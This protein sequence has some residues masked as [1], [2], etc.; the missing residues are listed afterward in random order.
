[1]Q[2]RRLRCHGVGPDPAAL[3]RPA[4]RYRRALHSQDLH[5]Q[6]WA[7]VAHVASLAGA[8][9]FWAWLDRGLW[10]FG[11]EWDFLL[12]RGLAYAPANPDSIWFPHNEHWSTLPVLLWRGLF[13]VFHLSS[14]WP[15]LVPVL[16]AQVVVMHLSWRLCRRAGADPWVAGAA[17][18]MLGLLGAGA[19]DLGWAFQIGFDG[20]VMFGLLALDLLDRPTLDAPAAALRRNVAVP[21]ALLASLMCSTIGDAMLVGAA[22]LAFARLPWKQ[23]TRALGPPL[24]AYVIWFVGVGHLGISAHSDHFTLS[25]FTSLPGYMLTG[26]SAALG[27]AFNLGTAGTALLVGLGAWVAWHMGRLWTEAP[28]LLGLS[29][30]AVAF[31]ALVAVGRDGLA[32]SP[33]VSRYVYVAIALLVPVIAKLL[34]SVATWPAARLGVVALL[35]LSTLG[36]VG[37]AQTWTK[38]ETALTS[39]LKTELAAT[40]ELLAAGVHDVS[41]PQAAPVPYDPNLSAADIVRLERSRMLPKVP[42]SALDMVNARSVLALGVW[43]GDNMTLSA[44]PLF[45]GR[46]RFVK[47]RFGVASARRHGC[48]TFSPRAISPAMQIWLRIPGGQGSASVKVDGDPTPPGTID[49]VAG[50]LVPP[51]P[52]ST[53][54]PV[55]LTV[56]AKG[57]GYMSDNDPG[58]DVVMAWVEGT[59]L[60]LC[61]FSPGR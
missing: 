30:A 54:Q 45:P 50:L 11:D 18:L 1:V 47:V 34:S 53:S 16:L 46:F 31:Y 2:R 43:N 38:A 13:N 17:V 41:G 29:A 51:R 4:W 26:L 58:A 27:Q 15:Y 21:A 57:T 24:A 6:D 22:V 36:N 25:T 49:Y 60:T 12:H 55:E 33:D 61:G 19:Q 23:A 48:V 20:S 52:P 32:V 28:A 9:A 40:G 3:D 14:Y 10:F 7:T 8:F 42:L 44:R 35:C 39:G 37:Q 59:A 5:S 56:P